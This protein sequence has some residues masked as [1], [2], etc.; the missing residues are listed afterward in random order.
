MA[1]T[2]GQYVVLNNVNGGLA[3]PSGCPIAISQN[4]T[5][6]TLVIDTDAASVTASDVGI[7]S[8]VGSLSLSQRGCAASTHPDLT[9]NGETVFVAGAA[10]SNT[11]DLSAAGRR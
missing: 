2:T 7:G 10:S 9:H 11:L 8:N 6:G 4:L 5:G 1:I 3:G